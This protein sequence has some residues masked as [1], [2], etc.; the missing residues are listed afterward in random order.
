MENTGITSWSGADNYRLGYSV[1]PENAIW[2][3]SEVRLNQGENIAPGERKIFTFDMT[4]P[5]EEGVYKFQWRMKRDSLGF[6]G[7]LSDSR[8]VVV[9]S[10]FDF[11]D[12]CDALTDWDPAVRLTLNNTDQKQGTG[13]IELNGGASDS[14]EFQKVFANPY[15]SGVA[16]H[17]AVIAV[18]VLYL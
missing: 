1:D 11:L 7:E 9:S 13:C 17:E 12:D 14:V 2:D 4:A 3:T 10:S 5:D 16:A 15:N 8:L 6:F 18:L